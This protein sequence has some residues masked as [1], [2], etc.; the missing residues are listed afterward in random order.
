VANASNP[1][2]AVSKNRLYWGD[3]LDILSTHVQDESVDLVYLDPPFNSNASY[4]VLY[5]EK[6]GQAAAAQIKAFTDTWAWDRASRAAFHD[7]VENGPPGVSQAMQAFRTFL[8]DNDVLAYLAMMAPRLLQLH[9]VLK[10]KGS[11]YL[12]CDPTAGHYL[13]LLLDAVFGPKNFRNEIVWRRTGSNSAAKRYGPLHQLIYYYGKTSEAP[14]YPVFN[15]YTKGYI[16]D[17]F[18]EEDERGR[19][20]PVLL[21]GPGTRKGESGKRWRN[22]DPSSSGRHW[23]PASYVYEKY[24]AVTGDDLANYPLLERLDKLDEAE[25]IH[26]PSKGDGVPNYRYYLADAPGVALQDVW[27]YQPGT[28]GC[29]YGDDG[30]G[31]DQDVKW[32]SP[33]DREKLEYPT[34]KPEGVLARIIRSSS[35]EGD[36]VLDPFCG[37]GTA[38]AVAEKLGRRWIGIDI[39]HV[40]LEVIQRRF[41][42]DFSHV[43]DYEREGQPITLPDAQALFEEDAHKFQWWVLW[44]LGVQKPE[45]KKGADRGVDGR[46]FFHDGDETHQ[47]VISV[48]GGKTNV[49][50]V[51]DLRGVLDRDSAAIG[52]LVT[53]RPPTLPMK[54]EAASADYWRS[55]SG[56][57]YPRLQIITAEELVAGARAEYPGTAPGVATKPVVPEQLTLSAV[58]PRDDR[59][60]DGSPRKASAIHSLRD[61]VDDLLRAAGVV[62]PPVRLEPIL[63][64]LNIE[65]SAREGMHEDAVIHPMTDPRLGKP[66]AWMVYYNP[67]KPETRRRFTIAHE[68][69]H[70]VLDDEWL[71][72]AARGSTDRQRQRE[73]L[74]NEFAAELLM[75]SALVHDAVRQVG[76]D[77]DRLRQIFNVSPVAMRNRLRSL[78]LV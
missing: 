37:C 18:K 8:G 76:L 27:A 53:L 61:I 10:P 26:W 72:S 12:H 20:R 77:A 66:S 55:P 16:R 75:P 64:R 56:H 44:K 54:R 4:N 28:E 73:R 15:P 62:A 5:K 65:L 78:R 59:L 22:Y 74:M 23:Q 39:T 68:I 71:A 42:K 34:Q 48:K 19:Y 1:Q 25:L 69:G 50:A 9:R 70:S 49:S 40:A 67:R 41:E 33:K 57:W 3:N 13:K 2:L 29:V 31:I 36:V 11:L 35:R 45:L 63:Q 17:Y 51:R 60:G 58:T 7:V 43:P 30:V 47:A 14:Y 46:L 21:T 32:L 52:V 24:R 6:D 38:I